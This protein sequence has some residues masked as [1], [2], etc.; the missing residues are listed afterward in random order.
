MFDDILKQI[1]GS[2]I[3]KKLSDTINENE[4]LKKIKDSIGDNDYVKKIQDGLQGGNLLDK[5]KAGAGSAGK[6][7]TRVAL[8]CYHV[9]QAET[10]PTVDKIIIGA[11]LA[12]QFLPNLMDKDNFGPILSLLDNAVTLAIAYN[13]VKAHVTPEIQ[14]KVDA[15]LAQWFHDDT[16][17]P[18]PD[19]E[20][21]PA[22]ELAESAP[23]AEAPA[24]DAP[25]A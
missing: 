7:A 2:D 11:A 14:D 17:Q 24:E 5:I 22:D 1:L 6:Q 19:T 21:A 12:Y 13:R 8:Q 9:M 25:Q 16:T 3:V 15:Q 23:T 4:F 18:I 10:T 20:A